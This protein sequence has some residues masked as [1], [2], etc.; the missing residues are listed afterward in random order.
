MTRGPDKQFDRKAVLGKAMQLF[1]SQGYEATGVAQLLEHM[2][3]GRQSLYDT[4]GDKRG[5]YLEALRAYFAE[6]RASVVARLQ[7]SGSPLANLKAVFAQ[8]EKML[9][10]TGPFGCL[11]GNTAVELGP[12]DQE[13]ARIV[14]A[15]F[16]GMSQEIAETIRQGQE[17]GE[18]RAGDPSELSSL[19]VATIQGAALL[20]KVEPGM[21]TSHAALRGV[22]ALLAGD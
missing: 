8:W 17:A 6:Q 22:L 16:A 4:F 11:I 20:S 14:R 5:L 15:A 12:H 1:W 19:I 2:G 13:A 3:I 7:A 9:T 18:I 10:E 21:R